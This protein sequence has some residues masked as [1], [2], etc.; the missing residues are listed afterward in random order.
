MIN[1]NPTFTMKRSILC[2]LPLY[3]LLVACGKR[4]EAKRSPAEPP[5]VPAAIAEVL[6]KSP[7]GEPKAIHEAKDGLKPGDEVVLTGKVMGG[8]RPF[9]EGRAAFTLGDPAVLTPCNEI[10]GDSCETPW[11]VCC[12]T[13]EDK[14][15]ATVSIQIIDAGGRVLKHGLQG[16]G[17]L[18]HLAKITVAGKV[19]EGS[20]DGAVI[21]NAHAIR[22][23][24]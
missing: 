17:G 10:P 19:S 23:E 11:D 14:K 1:H 7:A 15:R 13:P 3:L 8:A 21:I 2:L 18:D 20:S 16:V 5:A 12:E 24:K 6:A 9:V 22:V 4:E